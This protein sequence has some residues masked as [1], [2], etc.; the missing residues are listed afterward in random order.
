MLAKSE[1]V[2]AVECAL[3]E[4]IETVRSNAELKDRLL[5]FE[6][7]IVKRL[8]LRHYCSDFNMFYTK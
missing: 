3:A 1:Q 4:D 7:D 5:W 8:Y 2:Q 6:A